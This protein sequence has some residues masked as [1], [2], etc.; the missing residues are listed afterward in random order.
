M[1]RMDKAAA[2][3]G[4]TLPW[5]KRM[6]GGNVDSGQNR[7]QTED[8]PNG[9]QQVKGQ[10]SQG[11]SRQLETYSRQKEWVS[12]TDNHVGGSLTLC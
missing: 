6:S 10:R 11:T 5:G 4:L 1:H 7:K 9:R 8:N 12:E 3:Q 2:L